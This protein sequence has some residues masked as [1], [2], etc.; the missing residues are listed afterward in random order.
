MSRVRL[1][2][3][4]LATAL[5]VA[6]T[7][8]AGGPDPL[9]T[10]GDPLPFPKG[11]QNELAL[12]IDANPKTGGKILAAG[13]N[14]YV[15]QTRQ[16]NGTC[17]FDPKR[18]ISGVYFSLNGGG[19][20]QSP[21]PA[22]RTLP[23]YGQLR[24]ATRGDPSLAFGPD[25]L[26][27]GK[28]SWD[29]GS[30]LYYATMASSF[31]RAFRVIAVSVMSDVS[32]SWNSANGW[33]TPAIVSPKK[34]Y[35]DKPAIWA[36]NVQL[37]PN[38]GNVYVC[39]TS[40]TNDTDEVSPGT[41]PAGSSSP[42][43]FSLSRDGG[44]TWSARTALRA[45]GS[46]GGRQGC[47]V[48]TDS[49]G[50]VY[51]AWEEYYAP[52]KSAQVIAR[53]TAQAVRQAG[54]GRVSFGA[55]T[56][57]ATVVNV[58]KYDG[59]QERVTFDGVAGARTNSWPSLTIGSNA[60]LGKDARD[61]IVVVW[62]DARRGLNHEDALLTYSTDGGNT[63]TRP[64]NAAVSGDRP[65]MPA[66]AISP[67]SQSLY[68]VYTAF[69]Q[70]WVPYSPAAVK[71]ERWMHTVFRTVGF[72]AFAAQP[73]S[74]PWRTIG[75]GVLPRADARAASNIE[76]TAEFIGDYSTVVATNS[77]GYAAFTDT[78][79]AVDCPQLDAARITNKP[80]KQPALPTNCPLGFGNTS[81]F[82]V[83]S[84]H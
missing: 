3:A 15:E 30:R 59:N 19:L 4:T 54:S 40:Y 69:E 61:T 55:A 16:C 28:F 31:S 67:D 52:Y 9:I 29:G 51:V 77:V 36:D 44:R 49:H 50:N 26:A 83:S 66:V 20:W 1:C 65:D 17:G 34:G 13:A 71:M 24:L 75:A 72:D 37:S 39:W 5:L 35:A 18:G 22:Y 46:S 12:A 82:G 79:D 60:P 14:D 33:D 58:G 70:P 64:A 6:G 21:A 80:L 48:R 56:R 42:V 25:R 32:G 2:L 84:G 57:I 73:G 43:W 45:K 68:V 41:I 27:S 7:S 62:A 47:A 8:A 11:A 38:F 74:A 23:G 53:A 78:R 10:S 76:L 81:G 63:W